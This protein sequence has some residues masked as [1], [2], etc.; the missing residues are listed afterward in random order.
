MID[1]WSIALYDGALI[2]TNGVT[3]YKYR[4]SFVIMGILNEYNC[5]VRDIN[6]VLKYNKLC[7]FDFRLC[8]FKNGLCY[9]KNGLCPCI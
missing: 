2:L 3:L 1:K 5:I 9:F 8:Y 6:N 4:L 7:R